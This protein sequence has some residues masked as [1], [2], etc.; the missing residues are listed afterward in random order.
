MK[1]KCSTATKPH[2]LEVC[3]PDVELQKPCEFADK[4]H[5]SALQETATN[6]TVGAFPNCSALHK[7]S[8]IYRRSALKA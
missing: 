3:G 2:D 6:W 1:F 4:L 7:E 5:V 8:T